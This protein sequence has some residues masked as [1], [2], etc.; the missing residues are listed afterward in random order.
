MAWKDKAA[1]KSYYQEYCLRNAEKIRERRRKYRLAN[2]DK[3]ANQNRKYRV[4]NREKLDAYMREWRSKHGA[5]AKRRYDGRHPGRLR[6]IEAKYR[7]KTK[8]KRKA[9][10]HEYYLRNK[11]TLLAQDRVYASE[12]ADKIRSTKRQY[13][14]KNLDR[15]LMHNNRRRVRKADCG[16]SHTQAQR[17][18]KFALHGNCCFYCGKRDKMT[19]DHAV[20]LCRGGTDDISNILPCCRSC[21]SRKR[22]RTVTEF[23]GILAS[24]RSC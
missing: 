7:A 3:I 13:R 15:V 4:A 12:N 20:P 16:G 19:V 17:R 18:A 23:L 21:N 2:K 10:D 6:E 11:E 14:K 22:H 5:D 9:Y 1:E 8:I 24:A